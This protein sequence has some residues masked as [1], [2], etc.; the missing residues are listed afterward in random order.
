M[1]P[2]A[3]SAASFLVLGFIAA[4]HYALTSG[5]LL[6]GAQS[7]SGSAASTCTCRVVAALSARL[8]VM[9]AV[10]MLVAGA[11]ASA[12]RWLP[13]AALILAAALGLTVSA[14]WW[15]RRRNPDAWSLAGLGALLGLL[16]CPVFYVVLGYVVLTGHA[17]SGGLLAGAFAL[18]SAVGV[19]LVMGAASLLA[20]RLSE[21]GRRRLRACLMSGGLLL[22]LV[23]TMGPQWGTWLC[24]PG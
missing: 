7:G 23:L 16:P 1:T 19:V 6:A 14:R 21:R 22:L 8:L 20:P 18:G 11:G 4:P 17:L 3:L 15:M 13:S 5:L 2:S 10:G 9:V 12:A 24:Q